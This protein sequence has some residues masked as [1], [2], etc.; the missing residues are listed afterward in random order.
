MARSSICTRRSIKSS[1]SDGGAHR[2]RGPRD[3]PLRHGIGHAACGLAFSSVRLVRPVTTNECVDEFP[4]ILQ[5]L[6]DAIRIRLRAG[7]LAVPLL[8]WGLLGGRVI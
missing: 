7:R 6:I 3:I 1:R 4:R 2:E 8:R 5:K